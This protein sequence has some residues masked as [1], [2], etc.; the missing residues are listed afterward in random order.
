MKFR[1]FILSAITLFSSVGFGKG[2]SPIPVTL[3]EKRNIQTEIGTFEILPGE[4]GMY[5]PFRDREPASEEELIEYGYLGYG[6]LAETINIGGIT[7]GAYT[8]VRFPAMNAHGDEDI[9]FTPS[10]GMRFAGVIFVGNKEISLDTHET[11]L[12]K[13]LQYELRRDG[14]VKI[15]GEL[16]VDATV[17]GFP[18]AGGTPITIEGKREGILAQN[19][20]AARL[21]L[22]TIAQLYDRPT[23]GA[24]IPLDID[25]I[26]IQGEAQHLKTNPE[27]DYLQVI[28]QGS[29]LVG[30]NGGVLVKDDIHYSNIT[31]APVYS[32][33]ARRTTLNG[34]QVE[35]D[36]QFYPDGSI[37]SAI[38]A[39]GVKQTVAGFALEGYHYPLYFR[40]NGQPLQVYTNQKL[41]LNLSTGEKVWG[42]FGVVLFDAQSQA[43]LVF[44]SQVNGGNEGNLFEMHDGVATAVPANSPIRRLEFNTYTGPSEA[45]ISFLGGL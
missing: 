21:L 24:A 36:V 4:I 10:G 2:L 7:L 42:Y 6:Q 15:H 45:M 34:V 18:L 33:L 12:T 43:R 40:P 39:F 23:S 5:W 38:P 26:V 9:T 30:A 35:A 14:M 31:G 22:G 16:S 29:R 32:H 20:A 8:P 1:N 41:E 27:Y 19:P 44:L 28:F 3:S 25:D 11:A 13:K 37:R 17:D